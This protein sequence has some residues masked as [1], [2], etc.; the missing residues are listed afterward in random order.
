MWSVSE[1]TE[2]LWTVN[3]NQVANIWAKFGPVIDRYG[4]GVLEF[5]NRAQRGWGD[6][7][8]QPDVAQKVSQGQMFVKDSFTI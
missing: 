4:F 6:G 8:V 3:F 7:S 1:G 2:T 5:M